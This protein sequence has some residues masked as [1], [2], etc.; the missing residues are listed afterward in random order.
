MSDPRIRAALDTRLLLLA[1][2][3]PVAWQGEAFSPVPGQAYLEAWLLPA[4]NRSLDIAHDDTSHT[5]IF[6]VNLCYPDGAGTVAVEAAGQQLQALFPPA[7]PPLVFEGVT[8]RITR[9]PD[10]G[11]PLDGRPGLI[12]IPVSISYEAIF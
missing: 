8:T 12:V 7:G 1:D 11:A 5:G 3:P 9:K 4:R 10:I 2:S 6:Q